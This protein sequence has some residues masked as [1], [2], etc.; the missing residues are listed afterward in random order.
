MSRNDYPE[1]A[2]FF[3]KNLQIL[4]ESN[5]LTAKALS[6]EVGIPDATIYRYLHR[7]RVPKL[8]SIIIIA[9]HFRVSI[10]WL[11]GM[12][13]NMRAQWPS[14]AVEVARR[15][16]GASPDDKRVVDTVLEKYKEEQK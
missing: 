12:N 8:D 6:K 11:V 16:L 13:E 10:D 14:D 7:D 9:Q 5:G 2:D 3:A 4:I 1:Y 15:Y